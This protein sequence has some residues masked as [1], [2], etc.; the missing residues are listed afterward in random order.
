MHL[1]KHIYFILIRY[2]GLLRQISTSPSMR[3]AILATTV[4]FWSRSPLW[5]VMITDKWLQYR[6]IEPAD[7]IEFIF[8]PPKGQFKTGKLAVDED[9][10][11]LRDWSDFNWWEIIKLTIYKVH[12]RV[13]Q[14]RRRLN[15]L[16]QVEI[17]RMEKLEAVKEAGGALDDGKGGAGNAPGASSLP[18]F[19]S[20]ATQSTLPRRPDL[21]P[22]QLNDAHQQTQKQQTVEEAKASFDNILQEQRKVLV[23]S[24]Q[25]FVSLLRSHENTADV[26]KRHGQ[27]NNDDE[28]WQVWWIK[29]WY[30]EYCRLFAKE[31]ATHREIMV[32]NVFSDEA[33]NNCVY[34]VFDRCSQMA[35]E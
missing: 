17:E 26:W 2:H 4:R 1:L 11:N 31:L 20:G 33:Q 12:G 15:D 25:G 30:I 23:S 29:G 6:I 10:A 24:L 3:I 14:V 16:Q 27:E 5:I 32:A 8:N 22:M 34:D 28:T 13:E 35:T 7:V 9:V 21:P 19:P 18:L